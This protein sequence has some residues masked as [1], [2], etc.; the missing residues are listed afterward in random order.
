[1]TLLNQLFDRYD[2][3]L[4]VLEHGQVVRANR[5]A[6]TQWPR[7]L[8][9]HK[10]YLWELSPALTQKQVANFLSKEAA[11][12]DQSAPL[13]IPSQAS[14]SRIFDGSLLDREASTLLLECTERPAGTPPPPLS[15]HTLK[16]LLE[17]LTDKLVAVL[18]TNLHYL[19][20][21][22]AYEQEYEK[23]FAV[24]IAPGDHLLGTLSHLPGEQQKALA[25]YEQ[26]MQGRRYAFTQTFGHDSLQPKTFSF[27]F[28]PLTDSS[29]QLIAIL[30][31]VEEVVA[32]SDQQPSE[33]EDRFRTL[34]EHS[35]DVIMRLDAQL[36]VLFVNSAI[37]QETGRMPADYSNRSLKESPYKDRIPEEFY[38][39]VKQVFESG[40][41]HDLVSI[42]THNGS[43]NDFYT[44]FVPETDSQGDLR[45]VLA[46]SRNISEL[47]KARQ[48]LQQAQEFVFMADVVPLL[49]W[50]TE[51]NGNVSYFNSRWYAYTGQGTE[52]SLAWGWQRSLHPDDLQYTLQAWEKA[53]RQEEE[54][55][56]E[57]RLR[58][59]DGSYRW[60]IAQALPMRNEGGR[61]VKW[62]G[63]C[64]DVHDQ[65]Q[66]QH[67]LFQKAQELQSLNQMIPQLV[68]VTRPNG[69]H[70]YFNQRWYDYTGLGFD[71]TR[72]KGWSLVLHPDDYERTLEVWE[73]CL[74]SGDHYQIEYRLR[75]HDGS[76]RWF[77]GRANPLR[78]AKGHII[79]WF[80]TCTDIQEYKEQ[81][82]EL[83]RKNYELQQINGYLDQ[84]VHTAAHDLRAPV[85]NMKLLYDMLLREES[86][87]RHKKLLHTFK[88]LLNRL[89]NT[90]VGLVEIVQMQEG[91]S[92]LKVQEVDPEQVLEKVREE[93]FAELTEADAELEHEIHLS[94]PLHYLKPYLMSIL[95]N[96]LSNAIKYRHADRPLQIRIDGEWQG[97]YYKLQVTDNGS[98]I[99]LQRHGK[100]LFKPF[101]RLSVKST[102]LGI[103]LHM[104]QN[105]V[106]KNG[107]LIEVSS[108]PD[109]GSTF[110]L[111]LAPYESVTR[112]QSV[113]A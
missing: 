69:D 46:I 82:E 33:L 64:A 94:R 75:R 25:I 68:W 106:Q 12:T 55:K 91:H 38:T 32:A 51:P 89:D 48:D 34:A 61:I 31:V 77:I 7:L 22:R 21:T 19:A 70:E 60:F 30:Y 104:V 52:E 81:R 49:I 27:S 62:Y 73:H 29:D 41:E 65:R 58:R 3:P 26:V 105:M 71:E 47:R 76:Y 99:D 43:A 85:A 90:L 15:T 9:A 111:L 11:G 10:P 20:F 80:G 17:G 18:D 6:I 84:F 56:V 95:R 79:K 112:Q 37:T 103:G 63:F 88:P 93:L 39:K 23:I 1:M 113:E 40:E 109:E 108:T 86:P 50:I 14:P 57:Y 36:N 44:R 107:G 54:Y 98:G 87:E 96:L 100:N 92:L 101:K 74:Q 28:T 8:S 53:L 13:P 110:T 42:F 59:H 72:D 35:P 2:K 45:S 66:F 5:A 102:G 78:D 16:A 83:S 24:S 67:E 97:K 4:L